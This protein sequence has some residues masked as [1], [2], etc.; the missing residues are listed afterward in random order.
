MAASLGLV[1]GKGDFVRRRLPDGSVENICLGLHNADLSVG[2]CISQVPCELIP[3]VIAHNGE[4]AKGNL[5]IYRREKKNLDN[6]CDYCYAKGTGRGNWGKVTPRNVDNNTRKHFER[7]R[8]EYARLSKATEGGHVFYIPTLLQFLEIC[9]EFQTQII[10]PT[11]MFPFGREDLKRIQLPKSL[12][13]KIPS[14]GEL[15]YKLQTVGG[16]IHYSIGYDRFESGVV[17]QGFTNEWRIKQ[18]EKYFKSGMNTT[19]TLVCDVTASI[20][21]NIKS[22]SSIEEVLKLREKIGIPFRIIPLRINSRRFAQKVTGKSYEALLGINVPEEQLRLSL[23]ISEG[24]KR[25]RRRPNN[26]LDPNI[27][28]PDFQKLYEEGMGICGK[29]GELEYCDK[30]NLQGNTRIAFPISEIVPVEYKRDEK[31]RRIRRGN[32]RPKT[33]KNQL[34]LKLS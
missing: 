6:R 12:I 34:R 25:Y 4:Y 29:I 19:L 20:K 28:H 14:G 2:G 18:A 16:V 26:E 13:D 31:K 3:E 8:P 7:E 11:K 21:E 17:A 10:F 32:A 27:L 1:S 9:K 23:G 15:A 33:N 24:I 30:C 5:K 22:G